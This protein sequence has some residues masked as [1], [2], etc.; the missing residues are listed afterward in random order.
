[1]DAGELKRNQELTQR[2]KRQTGS[3]TFSGTIPAQNLQL[4]LTIDKTQLR[5]LAKVKA[6][7][8]GEG[9]EGAKVTSIFVN[10][11]NQ[12]FLGYQKVQ[13]NSDGYACIYTYCDG[14]GYLEVEKDGSPLFP[15]EDSLPSDTDPSIVNV[16]GKGKVR[17]KFN[18]GAQTNNGPVYQ[19][20]EQ[21]ACLRNS[22]HQSFFSSHSRVNKQPAFKAGYKPKERYK[23]LYRIT[24][25]RKRCFLRIL[26]SRT[27]GVIIKA[28]SYSAQD[29]AILYGADLR[30]SQPVN[31]KHNLFVTCLEYRCPQRDDTLVRFIVLKGE[32]QRGNVQN[33]LGKGR[34]KGLKLN[35]AKVL[36][37][38]GNRVVFLW[39][40]GNGQ[41]T[42]AILRVS[43]LGV[44]IM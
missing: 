15:Q 22:A 24:S 6:D 29:E 44:L 43:R 16:D 2:P 36:I 1:M 19:P 8:D 40:F 37:P 38:N 18:P 39:E 33:T 28:E 4:T 27:N 10:R 17:I 31:N 5:C 3:G 25:R 26:T 13:T 30:Q 12:V 34:N 7:A 14:I 9:I 23:R 11:G 41:D 35:E 42:T 21:S 32:C 20:S